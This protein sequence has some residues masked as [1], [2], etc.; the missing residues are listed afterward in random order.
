MNRLKLCSLLSCNVGTLQKINPQ[1]QPS[2]RNFTTENSQ[3]KN[4]KEVWYPLSR[5]TLYYR[6][7][8]M[9][10]EEIACLN[11]IILIW[12]LSIWSLCLL[13]FFPVSSNFLLISTESIST[14]NSKRTLQATQLSDKAWL[15]PRRRRLVK[16]VQRV[17]LDM[18]HICLEK[19]IN[20]QKIHQLADF[21]NNFFL[22]IYVIQVCPYWNGFLE[23][24]CNQTFF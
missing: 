3:R 10:N 21:S 19:R 17:F 24:S 5:T 18:C 7:C 9:W 12:T 1:Q 6:L 8:S 11:Q 14:D 22:F 13:A 16:I 23:G 4:Y 2:N 15:C 20:F